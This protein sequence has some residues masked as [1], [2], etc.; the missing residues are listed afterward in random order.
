MAEVIEEI[1][2]FAE[3]AEE[4]FDEAAEAEDLSPEEEEEI[5]E[6]LKEAKVSAGRMQ[7]VID[8]LKSIDV[9][10]VLKS[11]TKFIAKQAAIAVVFSGVNIILRKLIEQGKVSGQSKENQQKLAKTKALSALFDDIS[12]TSN[13]LTDWLKDHQKDTITLDGIQIPLTDVFYK[14]TEKMETV[15]SM[16]AYLCVYLLLCFLFYF[17]VWKL[18][19]P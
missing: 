1:G 2:E 4:G 7:K 10:Q 6:E 8:S 19:T 17:R 3:E 11:F 18:V 15:S 16:T 12:T 5:Q 14:Y 9:P 13:T